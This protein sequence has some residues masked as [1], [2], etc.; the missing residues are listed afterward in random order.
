[1]WQNGTAGLGAIGLKFSGYQSNSHTDP[2]DYI[3]ATLSFLNSQNDQLSSVSTG[4]LH[5]DNVWTPFE[6]R[7]AIP[8]GATS[9][10]VSLAGTRENGSFINAFVDSLTLVDRPPSDSGDYNFDGA[11]DGADFLYWQRQ[12]GQVGTG[13]AADGDGSD[14]D[15]RRRNARD[16][17]SS[18]RLRRKLVES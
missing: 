6:I 3:V 8:S 15:F 17:S 16:L 7:M 9:W 1:M 5:S 14:V 12:L 10:R 11:V 18:T 13:M 2:V 4:Q